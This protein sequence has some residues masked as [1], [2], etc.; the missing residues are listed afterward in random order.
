[1]SGSLMAIFFRIIFISIGMGLVAQFHW[2]LYIFGAILI[3]TGIS[4]FRA[5]HDEEADLENNR[6]YK[7]LKRMLPITSD[8]AKSTTPACLL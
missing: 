3:Y 4:M 7:L 8:D 6:V 1:M 5:E 2:I